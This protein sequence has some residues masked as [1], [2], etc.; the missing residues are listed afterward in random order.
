VR[1]VSC[2]ACSTCSRALALAIALVL[3]SA[4]PNVA[5]AQVVTPRTVPVQQSG[6]FGIFP[7]QRGGMA[8]AS[9]VLDDSLFDPF[10]NPA[11]ATR[12]SGARL[13]TDFVGHS[14]TRGGGGGHTFPF[15]FLVSGRRWSAGGLA[16]YQDLETQLLPNRAS[17]DRHATNRYSSVMLA[18][19]LGDGLSVGANAYVADLNALDGLGALYAGNDSIALEGAMSDVRVGMTK[20]W[21]GGS[22]FEL[23]LLHNR[24]D[25]TH[26]VRFPVSA[27]D[28]A[29]RTLVLVNQYEHNED[30]GRIWGAHTEF[31]TPLGTD[32][33]RVGWLVTANRLTHPKIPNYRFS[34]LPRDP[35]TT[36]AFNAG[37][38]VGRDIGGSGFG[39]DVVY[40][41]MLSHTWAEAGPGATN[42]DGT[43]IPAGTKTVENRFRFSNIKLAAGMSHEFRSAVDTVTAIGFELGIAVYRSTYRLRQQ[44]NLAGTVRHQRVGWTEWGPTLGVHWRA[45]RVRL[46]YSLGLTCSPG[47]C[48]IGQGDDVTVSAPPPA[49]GVIA[50]PT[51]NLGFAY[52]RTIVQKLSLAFPILR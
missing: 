48:T 12:L 40:E 31:V 2:P 47:S 11:K 34:N 44:D 30:R 20:A 21:A 49:P 6:Q 5:A 32:S 27:W 10:V 8:G 36:Y 26:D 51:A 15:G 1:A 33:T 45:R 17:K 24:S 9:F 41:P 16:A 18:R 13:F 22:T 38:G 14:V 39:L 23:V 25:I 50:S 3:D 37:A 46:A 42:D 19:R 7:S 29:T 35:G 4:A 52:G 43:P 28:P